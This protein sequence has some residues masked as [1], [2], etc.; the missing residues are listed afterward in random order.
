MFDFEAGL[1]PRV[2]V[3]AKVLKWTTISNDPPVLKVAED[4]D[5]VIV[6]SHLK[7]ANGT[8]HV[9]VPAV[10]ARPQVL[11]EPALVHPQEP[12]AKRRRRT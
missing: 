5:S 1:R 11:K 10:V 9:A 12:S 2:A 8:V 3:I 6:S 7:D 4:F